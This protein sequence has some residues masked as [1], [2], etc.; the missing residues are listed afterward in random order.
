M[1]QHSWELVCQRKI[2]MIHNSSIAEWISPFQGLAPAGLPMQSLVVAGVIAMLA[3]SDVLSRDLWQRGSNEDFS[4]ALVETAIVKFCVRC[5]H[6]VTKRD[7]EEEVVYVVRSYPNRKAMTASGN[8][9]T[10]GPVS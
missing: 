8:K 3:S 7:E 2:E 9:F 6:S 1:N 10:N 4:L 5:E